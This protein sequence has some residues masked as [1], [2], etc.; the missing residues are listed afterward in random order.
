MSRHRSLIPLILLAILLC[1]TFSGADQLM[2]ADAKSA[3]R[4]DVVSDQENPK[5]E[6]EQP[7]QEM[8]EQPLEQAN[9]KFPQEPSKKDRLK[10]QGK[11]PKSAGIH[12]KK[13][14]SGIA[15]ES[16]SAQKSWR[17]STPGSSWRPSSAPY[18]SSPATKGFAP[19]VYGGS[20]SK[21]IE[22]ENTEQLKKKH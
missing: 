16:E 19:P 11:I 7:V 13:K 14:S 1:P 2:A 17:P 4:K 10:P 6:R 20:G 3:S 22:P 18:G 9:P 12:P 8:I 15:S 5:D 21:K